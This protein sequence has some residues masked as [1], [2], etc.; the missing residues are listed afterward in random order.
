V[1]G[2]KD[3]GSTPPPL[4]GVRLPNGG[5]T[6]RR[7]PRPVAHRRRRLL[8]TRANGR[9]RRCLGGCWSW[10]AFDQRLGGAFYRPGGRGRGCPDGGRRRVFWRHALAKPGTAALGACWRGL[11]AATEHCGSALA[12]PR[13]SASCREQ[14]DREG[15][16]G[17]VLPPLLH[18]SR[19]G[20]GQGRLGSTAG[21]SRS[22]ATEP[23]RT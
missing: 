10:C 13:W 6:R 1:R 15:G 23:G 12:R 18:V 7:L 2:G 14:R 11:V 17:C 22:M 4:P 21:M 8:R 5:R 16:S 20:S 3:S 19:L 9:K